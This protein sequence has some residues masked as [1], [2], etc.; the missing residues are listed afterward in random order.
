MVTRYYKCTGC[1]G[2]VPESD[3][4][5]VITSSGA[6]YYCTTCRE[7]AYPESLLGGREGDE[8]GS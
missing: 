3:V 8:A 6:E 1:E 7:D 4:S 5:I 2:A